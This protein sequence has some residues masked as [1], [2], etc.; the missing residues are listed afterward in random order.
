VKRVFADTFYFLALFNPAD[1][2]HSRVEKWLRDTRRA[3]ITTEYI[4]VEFANAV[5]KSPRRRIA[6]DFMQRRDTLPGL[7]V[8][9]S[10]QHWLRA[11]LALYAARPDKEWSLTDCISF[12]VM[13]AERL[14]D[15][16][17]GDHHFRQAGFIPL[18]GSEA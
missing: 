18:F 15:A 8:I 11:G 1:A 4:L 9:S 6:A 16:L 2:A 17:T 12:R 14:Q 5:S 7:T 13:E 3:L 10:S